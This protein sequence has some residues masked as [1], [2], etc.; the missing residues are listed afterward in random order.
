MPGGLDDVAMKG[1][2]AQRR[3]QLHAGNQIQFCHARGK[4]I[5]GPYLSY[6]R[7]DA[8]G[9]YLCEAGRHKNMVP[10]EKEVRDG[11]ITL[12]GADGSITGRLNYQMGKKEGMFRYYHDGVLSKVECWKNNH[13]DPK[14][15]RK[16]ECCR[17]R[18]EFQDFALMQMFKLGDALRGEVLRTPEQ[19]RAWRENKLMA[20]Y[21]QM[22]APCA[23]AKK[24]RNKPVGLGK[25][26]VTTATPDGVVK[27]AARP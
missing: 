24:E 3:E 18:L 10:D 4:I 11:P 9:F 1:A 6:K 14:L 16:L 19:H 27:T 17:Q 23:E 20:H 25:I 8:G 22:T 12:Y 2:M 26:V 13:L 7:D 21:K 5:T 15:T